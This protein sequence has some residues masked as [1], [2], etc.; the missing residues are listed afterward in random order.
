VT[1]ST[2]T[3]GDGN[4]SSNNVDINVQQNGQAPVLTANQGQVLTS[5]ATITEAN[6][7]GSLTV[8]SSNGGVQLAIQAG[9]NQGDSMQRIAAGGV[10]QATNLMG[11]K[12]Q[13]QNLTQLNIVLRND[14]PSP[15]TLNCNL[16]QL[17]SLRSAGY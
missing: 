9:N 10:L 2:R 16:D 11:T 5:G 6:R 17:K 14:L 8:S 15:G 13:V 12:N 1:Q 4:L 3:A 7:A